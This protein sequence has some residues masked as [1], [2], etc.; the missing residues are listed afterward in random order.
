MCPKSRE[1]GDA[2]S[3]ALRKTQQ[4]GAAL[5]RRGFQ[6]GLS[7]VYSTTSVSVTGTRNKYARGTG[8]PGM[9]PQ[10]TH[11]H[12][13]HTNLQK[14]AKPKA[15]QTRKASQEDMEH[16]HLSGH[17]NSM[18]NVENERKKE[19]ICAHQ[20]HIFTGWEL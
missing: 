8:N 6:E 9:P 11:H 15:E 7:E 10:K 14:P 4:N 3:H 16:L 19:N 20:N 13:L 2:T 5:C 18:R 12:V 1:R 17:L